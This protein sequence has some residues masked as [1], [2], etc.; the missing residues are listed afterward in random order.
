MCASQAALF[1]LQQDSFSS[2][3]AHAFNRAFNIAS[4]SDLFT[5]AFLLACYK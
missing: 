1:L 4:G 2:L 5:L 3:D